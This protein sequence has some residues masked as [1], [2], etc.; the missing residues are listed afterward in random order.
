MSHGRFHSVTCIEIRVT[1]TAERQG[2]SDNHTGNIKANASLENS[3]ILSSYGRQIVERS[4]LE[5][6]NAGSGIRLLV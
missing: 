1:I 5:Q 3:P 2:A 4:I 6:L